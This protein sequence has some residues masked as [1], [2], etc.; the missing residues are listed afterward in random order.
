[1]NYNFLS[2]SEEPGDLRTFGD[3]DMNYSAYK[4]NGLKNMKNY[5]NVIKP[6]LLKESDNTLVLDVVPPPELHLL[7]KIVTVCAQLLCNQAAVANWFKASGILFHGYNG[8]GLDGR[9]SN[10]VAISSTFNV[11]KNNN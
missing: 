1:M 7:M 10:K 6:S 2:I 4:E 11:Y 9:N 5:K 3:L 8:G